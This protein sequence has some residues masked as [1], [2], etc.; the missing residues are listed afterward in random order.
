MTRRPLDNSISVAPEA[1]KRNTGAPE[2]RKRYV[3]ALI[4]LMALPAALLA[5][6]PEGWFVAGSKPKSYEM[7]KDTEVFTT[8]HSS[9]TIKSIED[10]V[11][12]FGTLMQNIAPDDYRGFR[13]RLSGEMK[14]AEVEKWAGFWLRVDGPDRGKSLAFDNMLNRAVKGTTD[15]QRHQIV[16]DVPEKATQIAFGFLLNGTGQ[17]WADGL[18]LEIVGDDVPVTD[19]LTAASK[20]EPANLDFEDR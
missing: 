20:K 7:G 1:R 12:G 14:S 9:A 5:E 2:A 18:E 15:W 4:A 17:I 3:L 6:T 8:G 13:V 10:D 11:D 16:L 19:I